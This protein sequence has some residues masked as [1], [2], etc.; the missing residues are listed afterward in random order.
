MLGSPARAAATAGADKLKTLLRGG[1]GFRRGATGAARV[2]LPYRG[3][4][5]MFTT[6]W[7]GPVFGAGL[8]GM[9]RKGYA[10]VTDVRETVGARHP[11]RAHIMKPAARLCLSAVARTAT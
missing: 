5:A 4:G 6:S 10:A 2:G 8:A 1:G 3:G 9:L 7:L 11:P